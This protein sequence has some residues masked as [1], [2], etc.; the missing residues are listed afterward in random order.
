[1]SGRRDRIYGVFDDG[2][3]AHAPVGSFRP[4]AFGLHDVHGN[5]REWCFDKQHRYSFH[6]L[7]GEG[8]RPIGGN[9]GRTIRGGSYKQSWVFARCADFSVERPRLSVG[10]CGLRPVRRLD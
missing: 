4:N 3:I 2:W 10:D 8:L 6:V 9:A 1:M 5:V 7:P